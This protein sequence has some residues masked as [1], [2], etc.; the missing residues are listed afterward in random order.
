MIITICS[1]RIHLCNLTI[2]R[3][4][5]TLVLLQCS[6]IVLIRCTSN[7]MKIIKM[8]TQTICTPLIINNSLNL[9]PLMIIQYTI[10][11]KNSQNSPDLPSK[12]ETSMRKSNNFKITT[13]RSMRVIPMPRQKVS[14]RDIIGMRK[15]MDHLKSILV[16]HRIHRHLI[17]SDS[18][19]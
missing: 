5:E 17:N 14:S 2:S 6:T 11:N 15:M 3:Y 9:H 13:L 4:L 7:T 18:K 1:S 16:L 19:C 8:Q 12:E 10:N